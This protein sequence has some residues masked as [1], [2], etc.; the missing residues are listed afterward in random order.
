MSLFA[1]FA[2]IA[3]AALLAGYACGTLGCLVVGLR[4]PFL[5]VCTAHAALAGA[6]L[7]PWL[8]LAPGTGALAGALAM[9][10]ALGLLLRRRELD[11]NGIM[12][13]LFSLT[14]GLAFLGIGLSRGAKS[15][16]LGLLWGSLLFVGP[17]QVLSLGLVAL[18][19]TAFLTVFSAPLKLLLFSRRLAATLTPE[20]ALFT[21]VL[22]L[23]AGTIAV[24]LDVVGGLMVYSLICNPA[25]AAFR[26]CRSYRACLVCS[27]LLGAGSAL[28][29][30]AAAYVWD[31]PVGAA[32]VF[33]SS[34]AALAS[35]LVG[36][37][38]NRSRVLSP[39]TATGRS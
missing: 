20:A 10:L 32:I 29:G 8:G 26:L 18:L 36:E 5:A 22:V 7:G 27:A 28:G 33:V 39:A 17:P 4:L 23:S 2:T 3:S 19:L 6:V 15:D 9:A 31:L 38:L 25:V 24:S 34:L 30:L 14:M 37:R 12:G 21:A 11:G 35:G 16:S 13:T 1:T